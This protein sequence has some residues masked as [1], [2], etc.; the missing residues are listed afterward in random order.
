[1]K[2]AMQ[3]L[4]DWTNQYKGKMISADQVVLKAY[5]L[6]ENEALQIAD[7]FQSGG[8]SNMFGDN[9]HWIKYYENKYQNK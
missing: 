5:E 3:E 4:I 8:F 7:A 6:M 9:T 1:M 2:T